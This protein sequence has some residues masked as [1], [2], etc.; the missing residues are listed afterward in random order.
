MN[1]DIYNSD[2][3][4]GGGWTVFDRP[5]MSLRNLVRGDPEAALRALV[6][7]STL[8][9]S[10]HR[11]LADDIGVGQGSRLYDAILRTATNPL[12]IAGIIL[13]T[14]F[15]IPLASEMFRYHERLVRTAGPILRRVGSVD[16]LYR[17]TAIPDLFK[18]VLRNVE[19][20]RQEYAE[21]IGAAILEAE[22]N[23][24][25]FDRRMEVLLA[26][27]LDGLDRGS[28]SLFRNPIREGPV[29]ER[30]VTDVRKTMDDL[31]EKV[32]GKL[33]A[34]EKLS[35]AA[36]RK[37]LG[38]LQAQF[39]V[40]DAGGIAPRLN[41]YYPH[42]VA[43]D[44]RQ[45]E[46]QTER[47]LEMSGLQSRVYGEQAIRAAADV[48]TRHALTRHQRMIPDPADLALV[49]DYL[50]PGA[51]EKLEKM[52]SKSRRG[53]PAGESGV[54]PRYSLRFLETMSSYIHGMAR[55]WGWT[56][57]EGRL[58][59]KPWR[60][61][62]GEYLYRWEGLGDRLVNAV[63]RYAREVSVPRAAMMRDVY[64]PVALGRLTF[65]QAMK[66]AEWTEYKIGLADKLETGAFG[67]WLGRTAEGAK[68]R[69]WLISGLR[70]D[71]GLFSLHNIGGRLAGY[72]YLG[73]LGF[74][75]VSAGKNLLQTILT[76]VPTIGLTATLKG[77]SRVIDLAPKYFRARANGLSHIQAL[78]R[79]FPHFVKEGLAGAMVSDEAISRTL[80]SAW[81]TSLAT[82]TTPAPV[83]EAGTRIK[84]AMMALFSTTEH[85]NR[86][87][88][89]EGSI[90]KAMRE[91]LDLNQ[92]REFARRVVETTQF[93]GG[94]A[95]TPAF[96]VEWSPLMQQF[97]RFPARTLGF[98]SGPGLS[99]GSGSKAIP[100]H[101]P[102]VGGMNPGTLG[103]TM[104]ASTVAYE[105]G[106]SL[107][108]VD[109]SSG[110]MFGALPSP[111]P[112]APFSPAP[113]VPPALSIVGAVAQDLIT[114]KFDQTKYVLPLLVP[115]G[116]MLSRSST[117]VWPEAARA[118]GRDFADYSNPTPDGRIPLY[119]SN[120]SLRGYATPLQL[121]GM[122]L[123]V[124]V[125]TLEQERQLESYWLAQRDRIRGY[126]REY[127]NALVSGD[128][129]RAD[130]IQREFESLYPGQGGITY[131]P[132]DLRAVYLRTAIPR[133]ERLLATAPAHMRPHFARMITAALAGEAHNLLG[134]D[135]AL[136]EA[137]VS[138]LDRDM[139]RDTP[140][141]NAPEVMARRVELTAQGVPAGGSSHGTAGTY[142]STYRRWPVRNRPLDSF[143]TS[144]PEGS[145]VFDPVRS[146]S[147]GTFAE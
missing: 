133:L 3:G 117:V 106:R 130:E 33:P 99:L 136:L 51:L 97:I 114:G 35:R 21:R 41:N 1:D 79:A 144:Q 32:L 17:G 121:W 147:F 77:L 23:G 52:A 29:F 145:L 88:A 18:S 80:A 61:L 62:R 4:I 85:V 75:P 22:R 90:V 139:W 43:R 9:P 112:Q 53:L 105:A 55:A 101:V 81:S 73:A 54:L 95:G 89:F 36:R 15:P 146:F 65:R 125:H 115:G 135:P 127:L 48:T 113:F 110:L 70:Q 142:G 26:A 92:A 60:T 10:Q 96:A 57:A 7:P 63:N 28:K 37:I 138:M 46:R 11:S 98:L 25:K 14:R 108:D 31:Y 100:G 27:R 116:L 78:E 42:Q 39:I 111:N 45:F 141:Q 20:F 59:R 86:L 49:R 19:T 12:A 6:A 124:P 5:S 118:L 72:L 104:L 107:F 82:P 40:G 120:G 64:I 143:S 24:L 122:A 132:A 83:R 56:V 58:V 34:N 71:R 129:V 134:V 84:S 103:R 16:D 87:V 126:R 137:P 119:T 2:S 76:T 47:L 13:A 44:L 123:G 69:D 102:V 91:G 109:L 74:N 30:L 8:P 94:P 131:T 93:V 140:P 38:Q 66:A 50:K 128:A 68:I 67:K